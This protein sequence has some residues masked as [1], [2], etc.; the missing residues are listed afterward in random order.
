MSDYYTALGV[1]RSSSLEDIKKAYKKLALKHH[2][3]RGGDQEK[4]KEVSEAYEV[5]SDPE[6]KQIYDLHGKEG[7]EAAAQ[8]GG[9][10][11]FGGM[12]FPFDMFSNVF[13]GPPRARKKRKEMVLHLTLEEVCLGKTKTIDMT[14]RVIDQSKV[15]GCDTCEGQGCQVRIQ[16]MGSGM[17]Q[18]EMVP[19]TSCRGVG[20]VVPDDAVTLV[21]EKLSIDV[22]PGCPEGH[23]FV[24][25]GKLDEDPGE[26]T[27]ELVFV[28]RYREHPVFRPVGDSGHL[29]TTLHIN[30]LEA[31]T[32][33][34][35]ILRHPDGTFLSIGHTG[36]TTPTT[37]WTIKNEG[38]RHGQ[39]LHVAVEI[40][41]PDH[42]VDTKTSLQAILN[43]KRVIQRVSSPEATVRTASL[44]EYSPQQE[45]QHKRQTER[46]PECVQQ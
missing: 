18:H 29:E 19:C 4:F 38:I 42:I 44:E 27:G 11:P 26:N 9:G 5:L 23:T 6:K 34:S 3:D 24:L 37:K 43:Q 12:H 14:R 46:P 15:R 28:V 10:D 39:H 31:L 20:K 33:F 16:G 36:I 13:G 17:F 22:P 1:P 45:Q 41:F 2:P 32:G 21:E 25:P 8:G 35:R 40:D 7:L 30:L